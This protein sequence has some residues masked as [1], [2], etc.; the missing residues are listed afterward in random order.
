MV[1]RAV[2]AHLEVLANATD[3]GVSVMGVIA[4]FGQLRHVL[5][6][7]PLAEFL[8]VYVA[9]QIDANVSLRNVGCL[10]LRL[11]HV[12]C[13]C[14]IRKDLDVFHDEHLREDNAHD[15]GVCLRHSQ[16]VNVEVRLAHTDPVEKV[17]SII[18]Q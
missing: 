1:G 2:L 3:E 9:T 14:L 7:L 11:L 12:V 16:G 6:V 13:L 15:L 18:K 5:L 8:F 4:D 17:N 10:D